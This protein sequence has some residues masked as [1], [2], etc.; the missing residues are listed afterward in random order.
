[1]SGDATLP[2]NAL[3]MALPHRDLFL[4]NAGPEVFAGG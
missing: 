3:K 4:P 2:W 1:V